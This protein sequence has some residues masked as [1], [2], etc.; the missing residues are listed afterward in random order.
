MAAII[1]VLPPIPAA[2]A[3][4]PVTAAQYNAAVINSNNYLALPAPTAV[5]TATQVRTQADI[6]AYES[7]EALHREF[8]LITALHAMAAAIPGTIPAGPA[9]L[10][11]APGGA[12]PAA[13]AIAAVKIPQPAPFEGDKTKARTFIRALKVYFGRYP[14]EFPDGRSKI[15]FTVMLLNGNA[16][17]WASRISDEL[18]ED[19][20]HPPA[21]W[22]GGNPPQLILDWATFEQAFERQYYDQQEMQNAQEDIQ[23]L[24]HKIAVSQ[25]NE[26]FT[27]LQQLLGWEDSPQVRATYFHG[28]KPRIRAVLIERDTMPGTLQELMDA[29]NRIDQA[30]F[31]NY[32]NKTSSSGN[33]SSFGMNRSGSGR[34]EGGQQRMNTLIAMPG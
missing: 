17:K 27:N 15:T 12:G 30:Q 20:A 5:E 10:A 11:G 3:P 13:A 16:A 4:N 6:I 33:S 31:L 8:N 32:Q 23:E 34:Q 21:R 19:L 18:A 22:P 9:G 2:P 26:E 7:N 24:R 29:S 28:L 25:Y 14:R 1:G